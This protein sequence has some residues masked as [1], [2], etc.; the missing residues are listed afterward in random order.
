MENTDETSSSK[1][2]YK[3]LAEYRPVQFGKRRL[4]VSSA[5]LRLEAPTPRPTHHFFVIFDESRG[6]TGE[7]RTLS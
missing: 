4:C 5:G 1:L 7:L 2:N 6:Y 3:Q